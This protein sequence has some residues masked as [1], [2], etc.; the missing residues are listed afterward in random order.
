MDKKQRVGLLGGSFNPVHIGHL[1][2]AEEVRQKFSLSRIVFIPAAVNP[3]KDKNAMAG[4]DQRLEMVRLAI[5]D[6]PFFDVSEFEISAE[7]P[8]YTIDT[9]THMK[10]SF[11]D[12]ENYFIIGSELFATI[13]TWKRYSELFHYANFIVVSRPGYTEDYRKLSFPH[14]IKDDFRYIYEKEAKSIIAFEHVSSHR[15]YFTAI[16]GFDVSSTGIRK[17]IERN[18]SV[19]YIVPNRTEQYIMKNG[20][21][22][23]G[24]E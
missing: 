12:Q 3:Q 9:L 4:A 1:R 7:G 5:E 10:N 13:N 16:R 21:Y 18:C 23:E 14:S 8:S 24:K 6:N 20:L 2:A 19:R 11:A 15:V 22:T 17:L